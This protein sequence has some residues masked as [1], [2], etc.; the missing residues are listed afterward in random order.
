[1]TVKKSMQGLSGTHRKICTYTPKTTMSKQTMLFSHVHWCRFYHKPCP[2]F[3]KWSLS[4]SAARYRERKHPEEEKQSKPNKNKKDNIKNNIQYNRNMCNKNCT[5]KPLKHKLLYLMVLDPN[6]RIYNRGRG[7]DK[8]CIS[9]VHAELT[10][11]STH[12][13]T[14]QITS[15]SKQKGGLVFC[16]YKRGN[17]HHSDA[18]TAQTSQTVV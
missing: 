11:V 1:M 13:C 6:Q 17:A 5:S 7:K 10:K 2:A 14:C 8:H 4:V 12:Y 18:A 15:G 16:N 3:N 9:V